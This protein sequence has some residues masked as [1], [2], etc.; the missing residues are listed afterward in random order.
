PPAKP[1]EASADARSR[2]IV[3]FIDNT[4]LQHFNR[5]KVLAAAKDFVREIMRPNDQAM[6][7]PW[8]PGLD[9]KLPFTNDINSVMTVI[10]RMSGESTRRTLAAYDRVQIE[11]EMR[12]IPEDFKLAHPKLTKDPSRTAEDMPPIEMGLELARAYAAQAQ[13]EQHEV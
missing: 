4:T 13:H 6:V 3:L 9:I 10:D 12:G 8:G 1:P 5:V 2:K 7:V 11:R